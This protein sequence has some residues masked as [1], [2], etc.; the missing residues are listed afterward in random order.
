MA[1]FQRRR[2][3]HLVDRDIM[4][5]GMIN[6]VLPNSKGSGIK[7]GTFHTAS[8]GYCQG[9]QANPRPSRAPETGRG[10]LPHEREVGLMPA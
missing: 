7:L 4:L 10:P 9:D 1:H 2:T 5:S 8:R 6:I 3:K